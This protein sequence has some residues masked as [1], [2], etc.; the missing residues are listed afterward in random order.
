MKRERDITG[1]GEVVVKGRESRF[2]A[3]VSWLV[4]LSYRAARGILILS[5]FREEHIQKML[6]IACAMDDVASPS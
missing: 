1:E 6:E 3:I 5:E 4:L 2:N